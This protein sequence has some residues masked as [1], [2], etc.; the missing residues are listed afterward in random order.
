VKKLLD[1]SYNR[2]AA[3][4]YDRTASVTTNPDALLK[5]INKV[6]AGTQPPPEPLK[7]SDLHE[8]LEALAAFEGVM[9]KHFRYDY[10]I[11]VMGNGTPLTN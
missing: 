5:K 1:F 7:P 10:A 4:D 3:Y 8:V 6:R 11:R 2:N 9:K